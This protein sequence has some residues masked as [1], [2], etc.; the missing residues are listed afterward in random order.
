MLYMESSI[1][2]IIKKREVLFKKLILV[3]VIVVNINMII[4][5]YNY[6]QQNQLLP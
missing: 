2:G 6:Y 4:V 5:V 1:P 3:L